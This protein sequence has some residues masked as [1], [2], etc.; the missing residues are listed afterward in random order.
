MPWYPKAFSFSS[1]SSSDSSSSQQKQRQLTRAKQL[2][3]LHDDDLKDL[4]LL[5]SPAVRSDSDVP[6]TSVDSTPLTPQPLPLPSDKASTKSNPGDGYRLPSPTR[7]AVCKAEKRERRRERERERERF[8]SQ[9]DLCSAR[10][11]FDYPSSSSRISQDA[12]LS[13][14]HVEARGSKSGHQTLNG[15]DHAQHNFSIQVPFRSAPPSGYSSP[16]LSPQRMSNGDLYSSYQM[17]PQVWSS[18]E[19][20][21]TNMTLGFQFAAFQEKTVLDKSMSSPGLRSPGR[22]RS[23]ISGSISLGLPNLLIESSTTNRESNGHAN[24]HPLPRPPAATLPAHT[25]PAPQI[26]GNSELLPMNSQWVKGKLIGRGTFGSVYIATNRE[27][28]AT[29]AMKE[30]E[31]F[32]DDP[33]SLECMKQLEQEIKFLSQLKHPNIV[34][35]YG[36]EIV[37]DR[38]HIYLEYVYPGSVNRYIREHG[39]A[40]TE[41]V[42]RNF[43]RHILSG[44][45]YLHSTKTIHRDIKGANLLVDLSGIVKLAD[46]GMAKHL[47]G[48]AADL[49][50]KGSPYWM[51][52]ELMVAVMRKDNSSD[53]AFA[54][55]IW[56]LGCTVVEMFT[57]KPPWSE[58]EGPA[59]MFKAIKE[60]PPIPEMLSSEGKDF[61][62]LCF[63]R[64]PADRPSASTLL[65]HHFVR[66]SQQLDV[67]LHL[68]FNGMTLIDRA[69]S[70]SELP[71]FKLDQ[72]P[73]SPT[74]HAANVHLISSNETG[75]QSLPIASDVTVGARHSPRSTL[76]ALPSLSPPRIVPNPLTQLPTPEEA[77]SCRE[78]AADLC[79]AVG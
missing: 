7:A 40:I 69:P 24:V 41:S 34:Q 62:R 44:L 60:S 17:V 61:L 36:S 38:F 43:T 27:T 23:S 39:G 26:P 45:A 20:P 67:P 46:F 15:V 53:L 4:E 47:S 56:S 10:F 19:I 14:D 59:A 48:Q 71:S 16:I 49:S 37:D 78:A 2:R 6:T 66:N 70:P 28:G 64:N 25:L 5:R 51:A 42:V 1:S 18:P 52:P 73:M 74:R 72:T 3:Y 32:S 11:S 33:N 8:S 65:E 55:D 12:R 30:V 22:P 50:L 79:V 54:V 57:G 58:C 75:P 76:D 63:Q 31:L 29:C 35:Y 68:A 9:P 77:Y 21:M 13:V